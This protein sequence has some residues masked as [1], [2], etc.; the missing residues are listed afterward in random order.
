MS[1]ELLQKGYV[2]RKGRI[3]GDPIGPYEGFNLGAT[4]ID[5]L[6]KYHIVPDRSYGK[7]GKNKPDG[8]VVDRRGDVPVVKFIVEFKDRKGLDSES[9]VKAFG[10]KL[11]DEYCRPLAC[12]FGGISDHTRNS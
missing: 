11:A 8:I 5:Q 6:R 3:K 2:S 4:T 9:R 10:E 12:E 1:E 7:R